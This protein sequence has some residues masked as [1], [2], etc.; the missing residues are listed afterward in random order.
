M[1]SGRVVFR[2]VLT[3]S[4]ALGAACATNPVTGEREFSLMS[5]QQEI[6]IGREADQEIRREM[7]IYSDRELQQYVSGIGVRLAALSERPGLPW[8][9]AVVDSPVINA[10]ALPGGFIYLTRGILPFLDD[11]AE[12]AGVLGHEI[13]HVTARHSAQQYSRATGAQLGVLLGTIFVPATRPFGQLAESG[14][15][16]LFLKYGREDEIQADSLGVRY[17]GRAGYDPSGVAGML[18]TLDRIGD[19][20]GDSGRVPNWLATHPAPEDRVRQVQQAV[21][22]ARAGQTGA[23][24]LAREEY[25]R[26]IDGLVY[27]DNPDQGVVRDGQFLHA[28]LRFALDFPK[29]WEVSNSPAQVVAKQPGADVFLLLQLVERPTGRDIE[30]IA[31]RSMQNAGFRTVR[32]GRTNING[33]DAYL[34]TYEG[35]LQNLGRVG[36]RAAHIVHDRNVYMVA[37][38]APAQI[39]NRSE[40]ELSASVRSFR[41]LTA[42]QAERIRP[43]RIDLYTAR[44]GDTWESIAERQARG[45]IKPSTLAIMNGHEVDR[46]PRAGERLKIVVAG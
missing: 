14:L 26:R 28:S 36:V 4:I 39:F 9:F 29:G 1:R 25:L 37:G 10:F 13:G 11:E 7:G 32:G 31:L 16:L 22:T 30:D 5:E 21:E 19:Q 46:Q 2:G 17:A 27:G 15:G 23:G 6:A 35:T 3:A 18:T 44:A 45:L 41:P 34:G 42:A 38:L 33:L 20:S 24:V 8:Q 12:L 43:N 40:E